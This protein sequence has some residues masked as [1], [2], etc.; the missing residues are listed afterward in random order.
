[1]ELNLSDNLKS[2]K[3]FFVESVK[4]NGMVLMHASKQI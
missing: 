3:Q 4:L 1:M 2:D